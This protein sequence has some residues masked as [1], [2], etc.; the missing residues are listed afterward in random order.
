MRVIPSLGMLELTLAVCLISFAIVFLGCSRQHLPSHHGRFRCL[1]RQPR[2]LWGPGWRVWYGRCWGVPALPHEWRH[3]V[4]KAVRH[5]FKRRS[6]RCGDRPRRQARCPS[7]RPKVYCY[8]LL[9]VYKVYCTLKSPSLSGS[10]GG[11]ESGWE[12]GCRSGSSPRRPHVLRRTPPHN[13]Q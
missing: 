7:M 12:D 8:C 13:V 9:V 3:R 2:Q 11:R 6:L 5:V 10:P 1:Q 4:G